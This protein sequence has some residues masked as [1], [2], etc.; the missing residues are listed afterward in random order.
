MTWKEAAKKGLA[1]GT[2]YAGLLAILFFVLSLI[3]GSGIH[4]CTKVDTKN[5]LRNDECK[6][7]CIPRRV[8]MTHDEYMAC[9]EKCK[10]WRCD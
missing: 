9:F 5:R 4:A 8:E 10:E 6:D 7:W 1:D 3:V 2:A